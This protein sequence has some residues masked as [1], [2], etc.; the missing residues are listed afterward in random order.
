LSQCADPALA[1]RTPNSLLV[2]T[3]S[4]PGQIAPSV[5][6]V[7]RQIPIAQTRPLRHAVLRPHQSLAEL[8]EHEPAG[9]FAVGAF[10]DD[11][12]LSVGFI[13]RDDETEDSWRVRG[14]A[15]EPQAR[16]S[17]A[18]NAVLQALLSH[19]QAQTGQRVW[20]NARVPALSLYERAGFRAISDR[21][22]LPEIGPHVVMEWRPPED[23]P[24]PP[25]STGASNVR[26]K[27]LNP[28]RW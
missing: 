28:T 17:G 19:A 21:F 1:A 13:G 18:G 6:I 15:T 16:G 25:S 11:E 20:C 26:D 8:A 7:T 2:Q 10:A 27:G 14:M 5:E 3:T 23:D 22:E 24:Q 9:A 4:Y 12:L